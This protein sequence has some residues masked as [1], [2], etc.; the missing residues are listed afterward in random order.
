MIPSKH[1][2]GNCFGISH[3]LM[4]CISVTLLYLFNFGSICAKSPY[5]RVRRM[6]ARRHHVRVGQYEEE[7][8]QEQ[9]QEQEGGGEVGGGGGRVSC[10]T[11]ITAAFDGIMVG[12]FFLSRSKFC[13]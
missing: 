7:Q 2:P 13:W 8:G 5:L 6:G 12:L 4:R 1:R 3:A 10:G 9:R 11:A